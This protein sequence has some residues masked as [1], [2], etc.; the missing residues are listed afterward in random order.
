MYYLTTISLGNEKCVDSSPTDIYTNDMNINCSEDI[1]LPS[2]AVHIKNLQ[3]RC[4]GSTDSI[5]AKVYKT[6]S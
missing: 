3:V 5:G 6:Q 1:N 2:N 4:T